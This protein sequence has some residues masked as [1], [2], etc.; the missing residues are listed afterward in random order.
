MIL[1]SY[2]NFADDTGRIVATRFGSAVLIFHKCTQ[3]K[4][5]CMVQRGLLRNGSMKYRLTELSKPLGT[6][7]IA[8]VIT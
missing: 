5:T 7:V 3:Q 1:T 6:D 8:R 4:I 2:Y